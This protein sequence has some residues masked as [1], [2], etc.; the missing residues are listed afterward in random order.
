ML[1]RL[2]P[3]QA[4]NDF[5]ENITLSSLR[6]TLI[7]FQHLHHISSS[8]REIF[9]NLIFYLQLLLL[10]YSEITADEHFTFKLT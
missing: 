6:V 8:L 9:K 4:S 7:S 5:T 1:L 2:Q 3:S 10:T